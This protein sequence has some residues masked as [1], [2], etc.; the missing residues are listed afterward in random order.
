L[1]AYENSCQQILKRLA[2]ISTTPVARS[3]PASSAIV[4]Q[5]LQTLITDTNALLLTYNKILINF[6]SSNIQM[7]SF[8]FNNLSSENGGIEQLR[9]SGK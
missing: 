5:Q 9:G 4:S 7:P 1:V 2:T 6:D 8:L 3:S